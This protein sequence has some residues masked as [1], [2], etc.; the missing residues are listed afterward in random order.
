[1]AATGSETGTLTMTDVQADGPTFNGVDDRISDTGLDA[2]FKLWDVLPESWELGHMQGARK[3]VTATVRF[4]GV[5]GP[6]SQIE[7]LENCL[8]AAAVMGALARNL[9]WERE[10]RQQV[11][12][13]L[14][15]EQ[16]THENTVDQRDRAE[17]WADKLAYTIAPQSTIGEH[18]SGNN[19]WA[20]ALDL[21]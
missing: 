10:R 8:Q 5:A 20:N 19:P 16:L 18:S 17:E 4:D 2:V 14:L 6:L 11:E 15:L 9:K 3:S 7:A 1:M 13:Q 21:L 12:N